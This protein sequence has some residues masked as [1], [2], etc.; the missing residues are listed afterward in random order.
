MRGLIS[1]VQLPS[2]HTKLLGDEGSELG[3]IPEESLSSNWESNL[4]HAL[5]PCSGLIPN[6]KHTQ[7]A[8]SFWCPASCS[9]VHTSLLFTAPHLTFSMRS[10]P[11]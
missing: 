8:V 7:E 3:W 6:S 10:H 1:G 4:F 2:C 5:K 11:A 9:G